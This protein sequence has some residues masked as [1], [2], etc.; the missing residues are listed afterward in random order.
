MSYLDQVTAPLPAL[1]VVVLFQWH[2]R[3]RVVTLLQ[4]D[5]AGATT[6]MKTE[7]EEELDVVTELGTV[8]EV[9]EEAVDVHVQEILPKHV[10][11]NSWRPQFNV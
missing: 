3:Y 10:W 6:E 8:I 4:L 2:I 5:E 7:A 9:E 11:H 1:V